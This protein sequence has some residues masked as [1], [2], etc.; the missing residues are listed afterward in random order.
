M[1]P[2]T[3]F[4]S[5]LNSEWLT[6]WNLQRGGLVQ[7]PALLLTKGNILDKL[8]ILSIPYLLTEANNCVN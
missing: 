2:K 7:I 1:M 8:F 5:K 6:A 3:V 4:Y